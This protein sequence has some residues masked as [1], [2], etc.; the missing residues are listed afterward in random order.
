M[1]L[2]VLST[3]PGVGE[4]LAKKIT[5][6][7]GGEHEALTS[8]RC[9]DIARVAEIDG[10]S[11]KR[12]LS[13]ARMVAGDSGSFLATK[14]AQRLHKDIVQHIQG[15]ASA[16]ATRQRMQ[17]LM[18]VDDPTMRREKSSAAIHFAMQHPERMERLASMLKG[19]GQTRHSSERYER[20][21][22]SK[23]PL[24]HL[25]KWCRVLQPGEGETWKDYTVF[26]LVTWIGGG[27][28]A[29]APEGWVVLGNEPAP[30]MIIPERTIDWFRNNQ[31]QL[32]V[33][34]SLIE[35][36]IDGDENDA[37]LGQIHA[38]VRGLERLPEWLDNIDQQGDLEKIA[39]VKDRL[40]KIMKSLEAE[41]NEEVTEAMNNA[42]M[43]LSGTE[44]LEAL[45]DGAA[46]QRK[47]QEATSDVITD[48]MEAAKQKLAEELQGTGVRVPYS[49]FTKNWPAKIERKIIDEL[50]HALSVNL[51]SGE[52]ER[53]LTLA[54][55]LGPLQPKCEHAIRDLIELDQWVAVARWAKEH[56]CT[57]P[58]LSDH[59]IHIVDGRHLLLGVEA[60]A[61]TYGLGRCAMDNDQQSL[62]LLT[63][64][65]SGGKTT[66][67]ELLAHTCILAH[68][69][70]P[71]PASHAV[72]G[73]VEA[74]H[75]LAKA[76][77]TQSAGALE[78]TLVELATV[79]SD[80]TPKL[81]LAD[82]L[83]A[84]TEPGA[85][86][87]IIAGMLLAAEAQNDTTMML[88]THLAPAIL[89]ATGRDDLRVDGIEAKGLDA[90]LELMV[91]RTP[92]RN[93]LA[94]ST[95]ELIVKRLVERSDGHAKVLFGDIL[96][97][98]Q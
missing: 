6:H 58:E 65:N 87:R 98:F 86:A 31:R 93:H 21:V 61:V 5:D 75:I 42:K 37:F 63:G 26:K 73:Q 95:P 68:M 24:D 39:D 84:I 9:G 80:P 2:M 11:P 23:K 48:A 67:L 33:L 51:A 3:L 69:G 79:V 43:N 40:W 78:Q 54:K 64:A 76:G 45:S 38:T 90:D 83:E 8:L 59:G 4:R 25:K 47:L 41:V 20:V 30:E 70:L 89:E 96:T 34:V 52:T 44:L 81:I 94:R 77:G 13:L 91:D 49:I 88:V 85:G 66:L 82:E 74:L 72:V 97:M 55:N 36:A 15:Y 46:F 18:P 27:S 28:P 19:L 62:A 32:S 56:G 60:D 29:Q 53:M 50:D 12:A 7:F 1:G 57:M 22:V 92:K 17:L 14:E 35:D 10:V 71:V 16:P